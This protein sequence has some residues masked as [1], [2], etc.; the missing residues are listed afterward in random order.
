M[1]ARQVCMLQKYLKKEIAFENEMKIMR[2]ISHVRLFYYWSVILFSNWSHRD[3]LCSLWNFANKHT[4]QLIMKYLSLQNLKQKHKRNLITWKEIVVLLFQYL[5]TLNHL[6]ANNV[7]HRDLKSANILVESRNSF[8]VKLCDFDFAKIA[9][10]D[11]VLKTFC[12]T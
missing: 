12:E 1:W 10:N 6:H 7:T 2:S 8:H 9:N 11:T 3:T 5:Q 4:S